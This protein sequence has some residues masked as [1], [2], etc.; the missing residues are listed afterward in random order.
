[1]RFFVRH[2]LLLSV[3]VCIA[4]ARD[5][6]EKVSVQFQ[7]KHQ[8]E[9]A[10][11]Y[12][13]K[14]R[15]FYK[16]AGL[17]VEL[18]E[19]DGISDIVDDV[20]NG[21][22][23]YGT[24]YS[25]L[26]YR[27]LKGDPVVLLANFF[28]Q[29]PFVLIS[30]KEYQ[31]PTDLRGKKVMVSDTVVNDAK[32]LMM[33]R[34]FDMNASDFISVPPSFDLQDFIDKK[35]DA[36][37]AFVTNETYELDRK[38]VAYNILDPSAYGVRFYDLNL[39]TTQKELHEHPQRVAAFRNATIRG[40]E[41]ALAHK[42]E[43]IRLILDKYNTQHKDYEAL[44]YE[45]EQIDNMI[46]QKLYPVGS[47]DPKRVEEIAQS[48]I[49]LGMLPM[50]QLPAFDSFI[51]NTVPDDIGLSAEESSYLN[52]KNV[53]TYCADPDWMPLSAVTKD[54][55]IG[56]DADF[57][58]ILSER[59]GRPFHL[60]PAENWSESLRLAE[61]GKCDVLSLAME[62]PKRKKFL[63]FTQPLLEIP[64]VLVTGIDKGFYTDLI[65]LANRK[66]GITKGYAYVELFKKRYPGIRLIEV[67]N[68]ATG[69]K[70]VKR[71]ELFGFMD[72]LT[73]LGYLVQ[74]EY[75]GTLKI[76]AKFN[77][78]LEL[79]YGV[80][81]DQPQLRSIL[82]KAILSIDDR[83]KEVI[84]NRWTSI[85]IENG[86]RQTTLAKILL[87][88]ILVVLFIYYRYRR[89]H[90]ERN[91]MEALSNMDALTDL[92]N[93]RKIDRLIDSESKRVRSRGRFSLI[94]IDIDNFKTINDTYGHDVG[95][96][97]L[98]HIAQL[99]KS[100]IRKQD[101]VGR[102]GG[103]EFLLVCP[104]TTA[105][106]AAKFSERI[107]TSIESERF[108]KV[109]NVTASFGVAEYNS[110]NIGDLPLIKRL[111]GALYESKRSGK[112]RVS[113]AEK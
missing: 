103:E 92:F 1:M 75:V 29:S 2:I 84:K 85:K 15:G 3:L 47:V 14:A 69:L 22:F 40:W 23:E 52:T 67:K 51:Y 88:G 58:S 10:G 59:L 95:D 97:V 17:D 43:I 57:L 112:N 24:T 89:I 110:E 101:Y 50:T 91:A 8:F 38:G 93:R 63:N 39:F 11:F 6:P 105:D 34:K 33:F 48:F 12:A 71:G 86:I 19:Y 106:E 44:K 35:V 4:I 96:I 79:G 30:Q 70:K 55:H 54:G 21:D 72:N 109:L 61:A 82:D 83:T 7:W 32:L 74:K 18:K 37:T 46:L 53:I 28:K 77:V 49:A 26:I 107:R 99:L 73:T 36:V 60:L 41:Y 66:I 100:S 45:A 87:A 65:E 111:D 68:V 31:L 113:V 27:Y 108:E 80:Q 62:T 81:K 16:E 98:K 78:N 5:E 20:L 13:A 104:D 90:A 56:M 102:W 42:D 64:L 94:L 76:S 9:F 25:T